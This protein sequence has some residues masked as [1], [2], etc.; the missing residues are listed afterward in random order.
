MSEGRGDLLVVRGEG[1]LSWLSERR[2]AIVVVREEKEGYLGC[3]TK[4]GYTDFPVGLALGR[5]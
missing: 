5:G 1:G 2:G 3:A 4:Q